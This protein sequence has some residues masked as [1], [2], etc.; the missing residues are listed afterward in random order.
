MKDCVEFA[1]EER[2]YLRC[3][4]AASE[5]EE[6]GLIT[7]IIFRPGGHLFEVAWGLRCQSHYA[8]ELARER[9]FAAAKNE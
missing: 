6:G 9:Q 2:V 7:G 4:G 8:F 3:G 5:A 1:L